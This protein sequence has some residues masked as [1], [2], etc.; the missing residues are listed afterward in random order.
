MKTLINKPL[1]KGTI[2]MFNDLHDNEANEK[3]NE[4]D[5]H[6]FTKYKRHDKI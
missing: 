6:R 1:L 4:I 5:Q 3:V 2:Y